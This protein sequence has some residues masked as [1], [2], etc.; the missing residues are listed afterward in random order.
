MSTVESKGLL[1]RIVWRDTLKASVFLLAATNALTLGHLVTATIHDPRDYLSFSGSYGPM[2]FHE[3]MQERLTGIEQAMGATQTVFHAGDTVSWTTD[4]C[5]T[6]GTSITGHVVLARVAQNGVGEQ[7]MDR[8]DTTIA[9]DAHRC[10]PRLGSFRFPADALP[11]SYEIRRW[12]DIQPP[13]TGQAATFIRQ[14]AAFIRRVWPLHEHLPPLV[15][16]VVTTVNTVPPGVNDS[17]DA[18]K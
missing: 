15:V 3:G 14:V 5:L 9:S 18:G 1:R 7:V 8:R 4:L 2:A 11:G 12:I 17:G 13:V 6:P 16:Q 10:G